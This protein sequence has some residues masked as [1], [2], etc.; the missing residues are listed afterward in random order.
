MKILECPEC[1][2]STSTEGLP[3]MESQFKLKEKIEMKQ[4]ITDFL[5]NPGNKAAPTE[6]LVNEVQSEAIAEQ[7]RKTYI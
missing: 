2:E 4:K 1:E 6:E 3:E 5:A 7:R